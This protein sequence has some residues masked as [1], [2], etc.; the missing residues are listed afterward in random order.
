MT[1]ETIEQRLENWGRVVRSPRFQSGECAAWAKLYVAIRDSG[2]T[3]DTPSMTKDEADGWLIERAWAMLPNH[4]YKWVLKYTWV[5]NMS[6]EQI[7]ARM[8]K[9]HGV[10]LRGVKS[11]I[12]LADARTALCRNISALKAAEVLL[13]NVSEP[14][15]KPEETSVE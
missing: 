15:C 10:S 2:K 14:C 1:F 3:L 8:H 7:R 13:K 5:W 11:E 4:V 9:A 12:V 6:P